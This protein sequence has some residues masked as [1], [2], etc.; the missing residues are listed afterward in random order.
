[1]HLLHLHSRTTKFHMSNGKPKLCDS[2]NL[3][4]KLVGRGGFQA[5]VWLYARLGSRGKNSGPSSG[6]Y[7]TAKPQ[8]T[9]A[10]IHDL[11]CLIFISNHTMLSS[12]T[13]FICS[14]DSS[15]G[16]TSSNS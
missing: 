2:W 12:H 15:T 6:K 3:L 1:M 14:S 10:S 16:W 13:K 4:G 8:P 9:M 11:A 7:G 5:P